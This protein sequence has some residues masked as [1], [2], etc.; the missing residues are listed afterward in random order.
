MEQALSALKAALT[1]DISCPE[2]QEPM[3]NRAELRN[4]TRNVNTYANSVIESS[5]AVRKFMGVL[6]N[7]YLSYGFN[8]RRKWMCTLR[9]WTVETVVATFYNSGS[10]KFHPLPVPKYFFNWCF[11][12]FENFTICGTELLQIMQIRGKEVRIQTAILFLEFRL[13][14]C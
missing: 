9:K 7:V 10:R 6:T 3:N 2:Q 11:E 4:T 1:A 12:C 8:Y 14:T 5:S 13:R